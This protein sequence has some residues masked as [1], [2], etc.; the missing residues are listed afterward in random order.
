[1][2][3]RWRI[4]LFGHL[5]ARQGDQVITRFQTKIGTLLAYLA[6]HRKAHLRD[7]L[8][9]LLWPECAPAIGRNNLS[10]SLSWLRRQLDAGSAGVPPAWSEAGGTPALP[11]LALIVA[12][13]TTV[14][15]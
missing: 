10:V 11:A 3:T 9:E 15:F 5:C 13:R 6:Y 14:R 12:A 4:E 2:E 1:M 7:A 8:V